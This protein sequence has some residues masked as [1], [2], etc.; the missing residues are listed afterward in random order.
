MHTTSAVA[1][2]LSGVELV[3]SLFSAFGKGDIPYILSHVTQDCH[4][5]APGKGMVP[6]G[7]EYIG[8]EGVARFFE[9]LFRT[10]EI[11]FFQPREFFAKGDDVVVLGSEESRIIKTGKI[12]RSNWTMVFR[13]RDGM[14]YDW[15]QLFDSAAYAQAHQEN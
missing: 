13:M 10:E 12:A 7:G 3:Q 2:Q 9:T 11:T 4:W 1:T 6:I 15:E 8:P 14:V 5:A